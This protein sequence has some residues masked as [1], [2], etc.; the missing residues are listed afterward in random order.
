M[1]FFL[2]GSRQIIALQPQAGRARLSLLMEE[3]TAEVRRKAPPC[4]NPRCESPGDNVRLQFIPAGFTGEP[5][6][7]DPDEWW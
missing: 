4:G 1:P 5:A 6:A 7:K 3:A 2:I